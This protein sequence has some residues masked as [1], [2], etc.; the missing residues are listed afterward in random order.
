MLLSHG[1]SFAGEARKQSAPVRPA[2]AKAA[3]PAKSPAQTA[4][5]PATPPAVLPA[6]LPAVTPAAPPAALSAQPAAQSAQPASQPP[7]QHSE[8][9]QPEPA[10]A[11][12]LSAPMKFG[13]GT[14]K[15][16][17]HLG[18]L[19]CPN[20]FHRQL[21]R[22]ALIS[23]TALHPPRLSE[24]PK[25]CQTRRPKRLRQTFPSGR[26]VW[27]VQ[28]QG[29]DRKALIFAH[30]HLSNKLAAGDPAHARTQCHNVSYKYTQY[31]KVYM[32]MGL[33]TYIDPARL[34]KKGSLYR[35]RDL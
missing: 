4:S 17:E 30:V 18:K 31:I 12:S 2:Q 27:G 29:F 10:Q 25:G 5:P 7:V 14:G 21:F 22:P 9:V 26:V 28:L 34:K 11:V 35:D 19:V 15:M 33:Y 32:N 13:K 23:L 20:L 6:A 24:L 1:F 3:P 8:P 16:S